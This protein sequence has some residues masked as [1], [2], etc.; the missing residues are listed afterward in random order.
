MSER[1]YEHIHHIYYRM[2][3][4]F[5]EI[6]R[7]KERGNENPLFKSEATSRQVENPAV[8]KISRLVSSAPLHIYTMAIKLRV[9]NSL[10]EFILCEIRS[11]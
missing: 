3:P 1:E 9:F 10:R 8:V 7:N 4:G 2:N 6:T 11:F 5:L